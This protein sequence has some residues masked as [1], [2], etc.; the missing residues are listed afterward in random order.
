M[1]ES[2]K[3]ENPGMIRFQM[4]I[5]KEQVDGLERLRQLCGYAT[6][7]ET[8]QSVLRLHLHLEGQ[9][10]DYEPPFHEGTD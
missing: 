5:T 8:A 1:N 3:K 6:L 4:L 10:E 2:H 7:E 9:P